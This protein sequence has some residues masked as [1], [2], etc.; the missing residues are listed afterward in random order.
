MHNKILLTALLLFN[1]LTVATFNALGSAKC[2]GLF[3]N[4][5][6]IEKIWRPTSGS[7][8]DKLRSN[9]RYFW[10]WARA[11]LPLELFRKGA[12]PKA[13]GTVGVISG[14]P[15]ILN[16]TEMLINGKRK[17]RLVDLD[18]VGRGPFILDFA[19]YIAACRA[20]Y[21][22][23]STESVF[24]NYLLGLNHEKVEKPDFVEKALKISKKREEEKQER[25]VDKRAEKKTFRLGKD[26]QLE[27][28]A[29]ANA[30]TLRLFRSGEPYFLEALDELKGAKILDTAYM[31][32]KTGGS[33]GFRRFWYLLDH[34]GEKKIIEFKQVS[35]AG[36]EE[37]MTQK[38]FFT[39]TEEAMD[40]YWKEER[41]PYFKAVPAGKENYFM[42]ARFSKSDYVKDV[43]MKIDKEDMRELMEYVAYHMGRKVADQEESGPYVKALNENPKKVRE[44]I[45]AIVKSNKASNSRR[46]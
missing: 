5:E 9:N 24:E 41:D 39:R 40:V 37:Y 30:E 8:F 46:R 6:S 17:F 10:A 43:E 27:A 7:Q 18:D 4:E 21:I 13:W 33:R 45:E 42:R 36:P 38:D 15:H 44:F 25:Y 12:L 3:L 1:I 19:R 34:K 22:G 32:K 35:T 20:T 26:T 11:N 23:I 28:L 16:F 29:D 2:E 14:D 31:I